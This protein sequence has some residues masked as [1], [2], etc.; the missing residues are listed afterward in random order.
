MPLGMR[1]RMCRWSL[2]LLALAGLVG[3]IACS[4]SPAEAIHTEGGGEI[5]K[6]GPT[7]DD[8]SGGKK[9]PKK[10]ADE[11]DGSIGDLGDLGPGPGP[12]PSDD[13]DGG[14]H[15]NHTNHDAGPGPGP[16]PG[17]TDPPVPLGP[18]CDEDNPIKGSTDGTIDKPLPDAIIQFQRQLRWGCIHR[19]YHETR[20][21]DFI[22][23][24]PNNAP[25]L[26]YA[27][28]KGWTRA[29]V[30]EGDPGS[31]LDFLAMHRAMLGTL[32]NRFPQNASLF[33]GWSTVPTESTADDPLV[34]NAAAFK[35]T[36][37]TAIT[38]LETNLAS[39]T[40]D[41]ELGLYIET[42]HRPTATDPLARSPDLT[43][44]VHTYVHVRFDDPKSPIRMQRF[45]R[46]IES[47]TFFRLHG[48]VDR[49]WTQWR[50]LNGRN[51]ATDTAYTQA[52]HHA[53]MHMGLMDWNIAKATCQ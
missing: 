13:V 17:P 4:G 46:N 42:Q 41:D 23:N 32:R 31:G 45:N 11:D 10:D 7:E 21:W 22:S 33:A 29:A 35:S 48:W 52:M 25:R 40:S 14:D 30:Q 51:D 47:Q 24:T 16:G 12:G 3:T 8:G 15:T 26:E 34:A 53:C 43:T 44:G 50:Q 27:K 18:T 20:Q 36:M 5:A 19:E 39:F 1:M 6:T 37:K 2:S 38:R 9:N 49:L 28:Q